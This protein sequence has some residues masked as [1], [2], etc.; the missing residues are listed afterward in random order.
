MVLQPPGGA[1]E[2]DAAAVLAWAQAR[3][4]RGATLR[5]AE[6]MVDPDP[7]ERRMVGAARRHFGTWRAMLI[8]A[9]LELPRRGRTAPPTPTPAEV[10]AWVRD[11]AAAGTP[12]KSGWISAGPDPTPRRMLAA[13]R[14]HFGSWARTLEM[15]GVELVVERPPA[16]AVIAWIQD[17]VA[18]RGAVPR[19]PLELR[20]DEA[21]PAM[22]AAVRRH[23]GSWERMLVAAGF[24]DQLGEDAPLPRIGPRAEA[25]ARGTPS[26]RPPPVA[27]SPALPPVAASPVAASRA[28]LP[29]VAAPSVAEPS[30]TEPPVAASP[31][32]PPPV[33]ASPAYATRRWLGAE[34][35]LTPLPLAKRWAALEAEVA[36]ALA[37]E[38]HVPPGLLVLL[39]E[40]L[41][42]DQATLVR[43]SLPALLVLLERQADLLELSALDARHRQFAEA[44][45]ALTWRGLAVPERLAALAQAWGA[46]P[47]GR[48]RRR[49]RQP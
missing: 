40:A 24:A 21:A 33:A 3:A 7:V 36:A 27:A 19:S 13:G 8:A 49:R 30:V 5:T 16:E 17:V 18:R 26:A 28:L 47:T 10:L 22:V 31:A 11:L 15:A 32:P 20:R 37:D 45:R 38:R 6:L 42:A 43:P 35:V 29:P 14:V 34:V 1:S 4:Q 9:G 12:L 41:E 48:R 2:V 25:A 23:F 44:V 39:T 46:P